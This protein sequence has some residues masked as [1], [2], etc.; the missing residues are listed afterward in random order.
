MRSIEH[1]I[2]KYEELDERAKEKARKWCASNVFNYSHDWEYTLD[3]AVRVGA[4]IGIEIDTIR[5]SRRT[6]AIY[7]SGFWSQGDGACF[8]GT[9]RYAKEAAKKI[10]EYAPHDEELHSI[11]DALQDIQRR[12][13]YK[14]IARCKQSGR[15]CHSGCMSVEVEHDDDRY[16][17]I[18][19]AED[20]IKQAL[21]D[22]ANWIYQQ[23]EAEYEY[24]TSEEVVAES[25][26]ANEYEFNED[27]SPS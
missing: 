3:D 11:T 2:F 22:F 25:I 23:L 13:F 14:L 4:I 26:I 8:E 24:Q 1:A 5:G 15:Y 12:N 19:D 9:Y 10:R 16:R 17:D 20:D 21:R 18:G 7:F 27:G 6:P